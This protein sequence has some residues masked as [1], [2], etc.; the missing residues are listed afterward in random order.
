[1]R[2]VSAAPRRARSASVERRAGH[3]G[4]DHRLAGIVGCAVD[5]ATGSP[6]RDDAG[7][8]S[9]F[10]PNNLIPGRQRADGTDLR[11]GRH[12]NGADHRGANTDTSADPSANARA[13]TDGHSYTRGIDSDADHSRNTTDHLSTDADSYAGAADIGDCRVVSDAAFA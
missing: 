3:G 12:T 9:G 7:L 1:M 13:D 11:A 6:G 2:V 4:G 5:A 10:R 8:H